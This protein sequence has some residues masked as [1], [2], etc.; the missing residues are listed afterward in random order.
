MS[1][2]PPKSR[3]AALAALVLALLSA[4]CGRGEGAATPGRIGGALAQS[5]P[6]VGPA[7]PPPGDG[8]ERIE[9]KWNAGWA[10]YFDND[11]FAGTD[12]DYTGGLAVTLSGRRAAEY[13]FS[14]QPAL[15]WLD[16]LG[17]ERAYAG[18]NHFQTHA[19]ELGFT[20]FTPQDTGRSEP[21]L[22]DRPYASL[23]FVASS[24]T[25]VVPARSLAYTTMLSAGLLGLALAGDI[26]N[27]AHDLVGE[28]R[29]EGWDNQI[30]E[31]GEPTARYT[32]SVQRTVSRS[33]PGDV[34]GHDLKLTAEG[35]IGFVTDARVGFNFRWGRISTPWWSFNPQQ[36]DYI[37]LGSPVAA[38]RHRRGHG[39]ELY[40]WIGGL[41]SYR[42][43]NV[44]LQGQFR[45]SV[46]TLGRDEVEPLVPEGWLGVTFGV[47]DGYRGSLFVRQR[48]EEVKVGDPVAPTWGG[49]IVSRSY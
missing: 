19:M 7:G 27:L 9:E 45:D 11:I 39:R 14:L 18:H 43:Y 38:P 48:G 10:F 23:F 8:G 28:P 26:Q 22:D 31:G 21:I 49:F 41:L 33:V 12:R 32:V 44:F 16:R 46:H 24:R 25:T 4:T 2:M 42:L 47:G 35:N 15:S 37:N 3:R 36:A 34:P 17:V 20:L 29:V 6:Y 30:S 40:V 1:P 13:A 5:P